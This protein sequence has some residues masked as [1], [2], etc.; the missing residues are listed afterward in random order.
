MT[1]SNSKIIDPE[2]SEK[3]DYHKSVTAAMSDERTSIR[4]TRD[5]NKYDRIKSNNA[6]LVAGFSGPGLV[7]SIGANYIIEKLGMHQI[8]CID[9]EF[10]VPG[11]I[12]IGGKLR[13]P[14]RLYMNEQADI[15]VLECEAPIM[16]QG[17]HSVLNTATKWCVDNSIKKVFVLEGYPMRGIPSSGRQPIILSSDDKEQGEMPEK[18]RSSEIEST[19]NSNNQKRRIRKRQFENAFIGGISGG[20]LSACLSNEIPCTALLIPTVAGMP[21][22]EGAASLIEIM[23]KITANEKLDLDAEQLRK[24]GAGLRKQMEEIIRSLQ[25]QQQLQ[26]GGGDITDQRQVMYG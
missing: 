13:H 2:G 5:L 25:D 7:G 20:L 6:V 4:Y 17:I 14:F 11:V 10:I 23:G 18:A 8:A 16:I 3:Y 24:E 9:S 21:D 12:Y 1:P 26:Q 15:Y 22:P 19:N